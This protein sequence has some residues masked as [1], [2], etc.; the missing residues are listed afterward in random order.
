MSINET[1]NN[2]HGFVLMFDD[3]AF[4]GHLF[5]DLKKWI[6]DKGMWITID[7]RC[8]FCNKLPIETLDT[9]WRTVQCDGLVHVYDFGKMPPERKFNYGGLATKSGAES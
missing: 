3:D 7:R 5:G 4:R 2:K 1:V 9:K 8:R 6:E